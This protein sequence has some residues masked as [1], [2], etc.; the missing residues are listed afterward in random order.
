MGDACL[1]I[2]LHSGRTAGT[3][4]APHLKARPISLPKWGPS[5]PITLDLAC[6]RV[7]HGNS[8][9]VHAAL[10]WLPIWALSPASARGPLTWHSES[11]SVRPC[12]CLHSPGW[13][14]RLC[15]SNVWP[16]FLGSWVPSFSPHP[17]T[18]LWI[19]AKVKRLQE[20]GSPVNNTAR[21]RDLSELL[22]IYDAC[23]RCTGWLASLHQ[24]LPWPLDN[25]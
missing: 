3:H 7:R 8:G 1:V 13:S 2:L 21:S 10:Y 18:S 23:I 24:S 25:H 4:G 19:S 22:S 14:P 20:L 16:H 9:N 17:P 11:L 12:L 5:R 6:V 15:P